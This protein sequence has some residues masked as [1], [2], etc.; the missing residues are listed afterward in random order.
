[1]TGRKEMMIL[2]NNKTEPKAFTIIELIIVIVIISVAAMLAGPMLGSAADMQVRAAAN[3]MAADLEYAKSLSMSTQNN[4]TVVFDAANE[5][6]QIEETT[7]PGIAI[8]HP[9]RTGTPYI[10]NFT[11]D[12]RISRVDI[13]SAV[14][15][16]ETAVT[17]DYLGSPYSGSGVA[18][19]LN[20]GVATVSADSFSLIVTVE[21]VTGYITIQ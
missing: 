20:S 13:V 5:S 10:V 18:T 19:A 12:S 4:Y 11:N 14:F 6:Y 15:D 21:P 1:M 16:A 7:S 8:D 9:H 17:S 3:M 2:G